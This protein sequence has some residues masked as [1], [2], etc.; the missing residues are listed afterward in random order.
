MIELLNSLLI[1]WTLFTYFMYAVWALVLIYVLA[2]IFQYYR[3]RN[4][5]TK[6]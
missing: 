5:T 2:V 1:V 6:D 3:R 4:D